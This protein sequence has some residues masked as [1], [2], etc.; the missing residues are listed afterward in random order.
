[1][2]P[3]AKSAA[4]ALGFALLTLAP[5]ARAE[6]HPMRVE[7][8]AP[9]SCPDEAA[10]VSRVRARVEV[11]DARP[12]EPV[13]TFGVTLLTE[14]DKVIARVASTNEKSE[15]TSRVVNGTDC[16]EVADAV[17]LIVAMALEPPKVEPAPAPEPRDAP[18]P[19]APTPRLHLLGSAMF[20]TA[21]G[22]ASAT[23]FAPGARL[24][25]FRTN[26]YVGGPSIALGF[27]AVQ[28]TERPVLDGRATVSFNVGELFA[29]PLSFALAASLTLLP[30]ARFDLGQVTAKGTD[31]PGARGSTRTWASA[32]ALGQ[33]A[34][35]PVRPLVIDVQ[36]S[37]LVPLTPYTF[38][39]APDSVVYGPPSVAFSAS[40]AVGIMFL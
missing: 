31:I 7:Y 19:P 13:A 10:F 4:G 36:A 1:M 9:S 30:C 14:G 29:C 25:L 17:A 15:P 5:F 38:V 32:G 27:A 23:Q 26:A 34:F 22:Y 35:V 39:F 21:I 40:L 16:A 18:P 33:L 20:E 2:L 37:L 8:H 24:Q 3:S 6:S 11:R 28:P 12:G